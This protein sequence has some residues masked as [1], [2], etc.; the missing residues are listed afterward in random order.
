MPVNSPHRSYTDASRIWQRCRDTF[1]G[2]DAVKA[3]GTDYLP[4]LEGHSGLPNTP[5]LYS[6]YVQRALF[7]PA[8]ARTVAGLTGIVFGKAPT[9]DGVGPAYRPIF[10]DVTLTGTNLAAYGL[11]ICTEC[12]TVGR[13]GTLIDFPNNGGTI[14]EGPV[15]P[16]IPNDNRPYAVMYDAESIINWRAERIGGRQ[17]LTLL[18]LREERETIGND[19]DLFMPTVVYQY[20]VLQ[21]IDGRYTVSI[22]TEDPQNKGKYLM[23]EGPR[24]PLRR[25]MAFTFIPFV[26]MGPTNLDP[27]IEHPPLQDLV[28]VNLSHY[29]TSADQEHGAHFVALPTPWISGHAANPGEPVALGPGN[30]L[31]LQ[32]EGRAGMLEFSGTGMTSLKELKEEKRQLMATLGARMLETQ[33]N[34]QESA[35]AMKIRHQGERSA[36]SVLADVLGQHLTQIIRWILLWA[37]VDEVA[38]RKGLLTINPDVMDALTAEDVKTLVTAWQAGAISK[39]T[40]YANLE[41]GEWTRPGVTY[42]EEEK[43]ITAEGGSALDIPLRLPGVVPPQL[44]LAPGDGNAAA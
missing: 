38:S 33:K 42:E 21:L 14:P 22:Y 1:A 25:G 28:D 18:V 23:T 19:N 34:V 6:A 7:Y 39:K 13:C 10:E 11:Q 32:K 41:W 27:D 15:D 17:Q 8:I 24:Q 3:R 31:M 40:V 2:S 30:V 16:L 44:P 12:L 35:E 5:S 20:R 29:R 43:D 37:G 26:F 36:L 9:V 4:M